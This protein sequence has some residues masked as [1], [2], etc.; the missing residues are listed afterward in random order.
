VIE[1][2][3][4]ESGPLGSNPGGLH[5]DAEGNQ[6]Y[7]KS[8]SGANGHDRTLNEKLTSELYKLAGVPVANIDL[9]QW[10]NHT[11]VVSP[12]VEGEKLNKFEPR[13]YPH[14]KDL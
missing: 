7:V 4:R 3:E 13:E 5:T 1:T 6:Y 8:H 11:A 10:K 12:I 9:T 14:I 2:W